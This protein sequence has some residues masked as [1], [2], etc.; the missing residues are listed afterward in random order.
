MNLHYINFCLHSAAIAVIMLLT[1]GYVKRNAAEKE[2]EAHMAKIIKW[3][4]IELVIFAVF[5]TGSVILVTRFIQPYMEAE[6]KMPNSGTFIFRQLES[7]ELEITWPEAQ[8]AD[9]YIFKIYRLPNEGQLS[10]QNDAARLVFE[11]KVTGGHSVILRGDMFSGNMLFRVTSAVGYVMEQTERVRFSDN[12]LELITR[13]DPP[14]IG[15]LTYSTDPDKQTASIRFDMTDGTTCH[16]SLLSESGEKQ[17]LKSVNGSSVSLNFGEDGDLRI[18][19]FG[20]QVTLHFSVFRESEGIVYYSNNYATLD[21]D[22]TMLVPSD[23]KLEFFGEE[24]DC[25]LNWQ[26]EECDYYEVQ[27]L[28]PATGVWNV[29]AVVKADEGCSYRVSDLKDQLLV[30]R[31]A[32]AYEKTT[33][34]A[35]GEI[36]TTVKYRS[37]SNEIGVDPSKFEPKQTQITVSKLWD[38]VDNKDGVRP[39]SVTV[40]LLADGEEIAEAVL[41]EENGWHYT[42]ED[43][44][45]FHEGKKILYTVT[46][47]PVAEYTTVITGDAAEGFTI[48]NSYI[49]KPDTWMGTVTIFNL[50][51]RSGAG[52]NYSILDFLQKGDRVEILEI[53]EVESELWG[54]ISK[55]WVAMEFVELDIDLPAPKGRMGTVTIDNLRIRTGAGYN[56]PIMALYQK[57]DR[58]DILQIVEVDGELWGRVEKGWVALEFVRLD[59]PLEQESEPEEENE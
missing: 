2:T 37:I 35:D 12:A 46:E 15:N 6:N 17:L 53:I 48:T 30:L 38:D 29:I 19:A 39:E 43:V 45:V 14:S 21:I 56:Y 57:G 51:I 4:V 24:R 49:P 32:A 18:P 28:D 1:I 10:Y 42:F 8:R 5:I 25:W 59:E 55:G 34:G 54:R 22:R 40:N 52:Y 36:Q 41:N 58:V 7:G 13:F 44:L 50:R 3:V 31:V 47:D 27:A 23:I 26:E 16:V 9:Y 11:K 20:Q 33:E